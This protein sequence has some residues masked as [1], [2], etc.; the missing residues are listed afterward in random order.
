MMKLRLA[1][2][3]RVID[4]DPLAAALGYVRED[5]GEVRIGA[6]TR[7]RDLLESRLLARR[8]AIF[9]DAERVI[10][11]PVVRNGGAIGGAPCPADPSRGPSAGGGAGGGRRVGRA[12]P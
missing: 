7:H 3:D 9:T 12:P 10:A 6:M 2:P 8:V 1:M 11:D 4:I 5:A